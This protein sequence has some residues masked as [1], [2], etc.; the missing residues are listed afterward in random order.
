MRTGTTVSTATQPFDDMYGQ[1][2]TPVIARPIID[3]MRDLRDID[4][5]CALRQLLSVGHLVGEHTPARGAH[6]CTCKSRY[7]VGR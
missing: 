3:Q 2:L 4:G 6:S 7:L 1:A 5:A